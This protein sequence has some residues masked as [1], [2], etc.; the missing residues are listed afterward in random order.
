MKI[1]K[2]EISEFIISIIIIAV[3][4]LGVCIADSATTVEKEKTKQIETQLQIEQKK[5]EG[6][7]NGIKKS[8]RKH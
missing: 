1:G 2:F 7:F 4:T 8:N 6:W 3:L 5:D